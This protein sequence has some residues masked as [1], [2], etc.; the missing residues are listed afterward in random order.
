MCAKP[1]YEELEQSV[2]ELENALSTCKKECE[3]LTEQL[4]HQDL[5][6]EASLD[7]IAIIDQNHRIRHTNARFAEMLG[8]SPDELLKLHTWDWEDEIPKEEIHK[9]FHNLSETKL[10]FET[11]HRRKDGSVYHAEV[12]ACG[13]KLGQQAMALTITRDITE[14]KRAES[15]LR[16][17]EA[18]TRWFSEATFE[19]IF[20]LE[21]GYCFD[22][23]G[24]AEQT[25]GYSIEDATGRHITEWFTET[26]RNQ[27]EDTLKSEYTRPFEATA[28]R[29][30]GTTFPCEIL[31]RSF[32]QKNRTIRS[33]A[34]RDLSRHKEDQIKIAH[35]NT[36]LRYIIKHA[37]SAVAVHDKNL[38]YVYVS[39]SYL[40]QF[41][42]KENDIIGHHHY[43]IFPDLPQ[44]WK[45]VH[46]RALLGEVSRA[47]KDMYQRYD[48]SVEWTRWECRPWYEASGDVGGIVVYTELITDRINAEHALLEREASLRAIIEASPLPIVSLNLQGKVK[49]WNNAAEKTFGWKAEE[50]IDRFLPIIPHNKKD[51]FENFQQQLRLGKSFSQIELTRVRKDGT[52][53]DISVS[54]APIRNND[55]KLTAIMAILEDITQK[56]QADTALYESEARYRNLAENSP[57]VA[58]QFRMSATGD[59]SISYINEKVYELTG[60]TVQEVLDDFAHL[61]NLLQ[62]DS[63]TELRGSVAESARLLQPF[64]KVY[65]IEV[66]DTIKWIEVRSTPQREDHGSTVWNGFFHDVT[67]RF[68]MEKKLQESE[69]KFEALFTNGPIAVAYHRMVYDQHDHAVDYYFI[70]AN[71]RYLE[72]TGVDPRGK[73]VTEAFPGIEHDPFDWIGTFGNVARHGQPIRFQQCLQPNNRWYDCVGYQYKPDHF[74]AAFLEITEQKKTELQLEKS[75]K[76]FRTLFERSN[77]A[78]F[79]VQRKTGQYLNANQ[80]AMKLTGRSLEE[81]CRLTVHDISVSDSHKRL[82]IVSQISKVH[83][84]GKVTYL[85]PDGTE[86]TAELTSVPLDEERVY[87][88]ARDVTDTLQLEEQLDQAKKMESVGR[89]AGGVAHDF[90]NMLSV[91]IGHAEM[92]LEETATDSIHYEIL[93]EIQQAAT[94]SADLTRQLLAFA[95]KQTISP[96]IIDLNENIEATLKMLRRL[97]G[98]DISLHWLP[99]TSLWPVKVDP[100][101]LDQILTNL[102][103]NARDSIKNV[104]QITI[105]TES[106]TLDESYCFYHPEF[107]PGEYVLLAVSD[108]GS[109]MNKEILANIFEPFFTTKGPGQGTGLGLATVYGAVKQN[110]GYINVYSEQQKGTVFKIYLPRHKQEKETALDKQQGTT[111]S[112]GRETILL[113]EDD[114]A[115]LKMTTTMLERCGYNVLAAETPGKAISIAE[116]YSKDIHLLLTDVIMP[117]M[118]GRDLAE[119]LI[120][121]YPAL[122]RLFM[123]GYTANVIAHHGILDDNVNFINKPF[124]PKELGKTIR[125]VLDHDKV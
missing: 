58:F 116:E 8:Y 85:R 102:C 65:Q 111:Q 76:Q 27:I 24:A 119:K 92:G 93:H 114:T 44:R 125:E 28:L 10:S 101:Q 1:T 122:R 22:Q 49:T 60:I 69:W 31:S 3:L 9:A 26:D 30:D 14:R 6:M 32:Y 66:N 11:R 89:L 57:A 59:F 100:G 118:N 78:I 51:E 67:Q 103:V 91:I 75:E 112:K 2:K 20:L 70:D 40:S 86:R 52:P 43:D 19:A 37:N 95:R 84:L 81:I 88:I 55:G 17:S 18:R 53:I 35:T 13:A 61:F 96:K 115:I 104:G 121:I 77:D 90:N 48:G 42:V 106:K 94:R 72:L 64:Y 5:L 107:T 54:T 113:V 15:A 38:N 120:A 117:E 73:L 83:S 21:N 79:I 63:Q 56:K 99:G 50:V 34:L 123:S 98:E 97:I 23:N 7:G 110:N 74:V 39:K 80:A 124:T 71:Q 36:L 29:K 82:K 12:T 108:T 25:F 109:G 47:E 45:E 33:I 4:F 16:L 62:P 87:G 41:N 46:Q 68:E 105:E